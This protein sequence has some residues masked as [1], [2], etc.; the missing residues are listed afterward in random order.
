MIRK[1]QYF[2]RFQNL[3]LQKQEMERKWRSFQQEQEMLMLMEAARQGAQQAAAVA[4][5]AGGGKK[6]EGIEFTVDTTSGT[7][8]GMSFVSTGEPINFTIDWGDGTIHEDSGY[9]GYYEETHDFPE[10]DTQYVVKMTFDDPAKI[11]ELD[12]YGD[13]D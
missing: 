6:T 2:N 13:D 3:N 5:A 7:S 4:A 12:F 1:D 9:G 8:F 11:L 10:T